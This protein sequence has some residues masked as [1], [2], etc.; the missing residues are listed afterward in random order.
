MPTLI[1][2]RT[3][4]VL[5]LACMAVHGPVA[6]AAAGEDAGLCSP[7]R[8]RVEIPGDF[9]LEA[10]F[11]GSTLTLFN[12]TQF[13]MSLS[14]IGSDVGQPERSSQTGGPSA[15][16]MLDYIRPG[17]FLAAPAINAPDSRSGLL[18]PDFY[19]RTPIGDG[20]AKVSV[21]TAE[22]AVQ[23]EYLLAEL[24]WRYLPLTAGAEAVKTATE[25]VK[26][27]RKVTDEYAVC[28]ER[29]NGWG[30]IHCPIL[31]RRNVAFAVARA[32]FTIVGKDIP[33]A[34]IS[35]IDLAKW[36]NSATGDLVDI[37]DGALEFTIAA[38]VAEPAMKLT[39]SFGGSFAELPVY[40]PKADVLAYLERAVG[41]GRLM[42]ADTMCEP[43]GAP[44]SAHQYG[45]LVVMFTDDPAYIYGA[46][47]ADVDGPVLVGWYYVDL[48][49]PDVVQLRTEEGIGLGSN[50]EDVLAAHPSVEAYLDGNGS[51]VVDMF[52]GDISNQTIKIDLDTGKVWHISSGVGCGD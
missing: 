30:E 31:V 3:V 13:P 17:D 40:M 25:L 41:K 14:I 46:T 27:I 52:Y 23:K 22:A 19:I 16:A 28:L 38:K 20:A 24:L 18:P 26:E 37:R 45:N 2:V 39:L 48:G 9:P 43:S 12:G 44:G 36:S 51:S 50:A 5:L 32:G 1:V 33:K 15:S 6:P 8:S 10:C 47:A 42:T 35:G 11:D 49:T 21:G 7:D 29:N 4:I 34:I